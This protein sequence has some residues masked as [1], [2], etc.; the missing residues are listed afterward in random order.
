MQCTM[1]PKNQIIQ[2]EANMK[3]SLCYLVGTD[4]HYELYARLSE[5]K[6]RICVLLKDGVED[7][8]LLRFNGTVVA[9][10]DE[11]MRIMHSNRATPRQRRKTVHPL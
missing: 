7:L 1:L 6:E 10:H 2:M 5:A 9:S 11:L 3:Y 8:C 4:C